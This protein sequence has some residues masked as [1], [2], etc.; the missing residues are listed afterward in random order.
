MKFAVAV[1]LG[2]VWLTACPGP[3]GDEGPEETQKCSATAGIPTGDGTVFVGQPGAATF[4]PLAKG[5]ELSLESGPQ[6]GTHVYL[7]VLFYWRAPD[8]IAISKTL[9]RGA[10]NVQRDRDFV[11]ACVGWNHIQNH[12]FVVNGTG[13]GELVVGFG[14]ESALEPLAKTAPLEVT[15]K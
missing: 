1:A 15:V 14:P 10:D 13:T 3:S 9:T 7:D 2:V 8:T 4:T 12:R 6:G 5:A 11:R